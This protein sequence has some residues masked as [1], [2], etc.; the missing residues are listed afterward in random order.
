MR[1]FSNQPFLNCKDILQNFLLLLMITS[2][3]KS[4]SNTYW[5]QKFYSGISLTCL[6]FAFQVTDGVLVYGLYMDGFCF[7]LESMHVADCL[8]GQMN[9]MLPLLH[10]LPEMDLQRNEE[11]YSCPLYKTPM[12]AGTLS[13]TGKKK[14]RT[15]HFLHLFDL[16]QFNQ[17]SFL[18]I[19]LCHS[20]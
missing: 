9:P 15:F 16:L 18:K 13:T 20:L 12:R 7:D 17:E 4:W 5:I 19:V 10:M 8:P 1:M 14:I 3:I 6:W 11:D 2:L